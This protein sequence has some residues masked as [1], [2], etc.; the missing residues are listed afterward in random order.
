MTEGKSG[1]T[2]PRTMSGE[3]PLVRR[4][5]GARIRIGNL[6]AEVAAYWLQTP[7]ARPQNALFPRDVARVIAKRHSGAYFPP[8]HDAGHVRQALVQLEKLLHER[9][10]VLWKH[11][12]PGVRFLVEREGAILGDEMGLGKSFTATFGALAIGGRTVILCPASVVVEWRD[13]IRWIAGAEPQILRGRRPD[14]GLD[15]Q[16][17]LA[18]YGVIAPQRGR[19]P[20]GDV[21]IVNTCGMVWI[22]AEGPM[23]ALRPD[24]VGPHGSIEDA[25]HVANMDLAVRFSLTWTDCVEPWD[26]Y[27]IVVAKAKIPSK[28]VVNKSEL[29]GWSDVIRKSKPTV[30]VCDESHEL[31]GRKA[32]TVTKVKE[33]CSVAKWVWMLTG[34]PMPNYARDF[35]AQL[36]IIT[37]GQWGSN[38]DYVH[39]Y[40]DAKKNAYGGLDT[41]GASNQEGLKLRL[42]ELLLKRSLEDSGVELPPRIRKVKRV[43]V[44]V[45]AVVDE[46]SDRRIIAQNMRAS[47][48]AKLPVILEDVENRIKQGQRVVVFTSFVEH[49]SRIASKLSHV[50]RDTGARLWAVTGSTP[51]EARGEMCKEFRAHEGSGV[52]VGTIQSLYAGISLVGARSVL[53]ADLTPEPHLMVQGGRRAHR[54]PATK[55][56]EEVF[57]VAGAVDEAIEESVVSKLDQWEKII[58]LG[59]AVEDLRDT[60][61][62]DVSAVYKEIY[63]R[64]VGSVGK[65]V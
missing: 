3:L 7:G 15:S 14:E 60:L 4:G 43:E 41:T 32:I 55:G 1:G 64:F 12:V 40:C 30:V 63:D 54:P 23:V 35:W 8:D 29:P 27:G 25:K 34:T 46:D 48:D 17:I 28:D 53:W 21:R 38:W 49:V 10:D 24:R 31:L 45:D 2:I 16:W 47:F 52:F 19:A 51:G 58:G 57:Y 44:D 59:E 6:P 22:H 65:R 62:Y 42:D 11:Q 50:A 39:Y 13:Y 26:G 33:I 61:S 36:D 37:G 18:S 9:P 20:G 5:R 56:V